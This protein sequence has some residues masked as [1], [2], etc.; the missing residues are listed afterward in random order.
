M[1]GLAYSSDRAFVGTPMDEIL[2]PPLPDDHPLAYAQL[3]PLPAPG[4]WLGAWQTLL[5]G[6][7]ARRLRPLQLDPGIVALAE[8]LRLEDARVGPEAGVLCARAGISAAWRLTYGQV[9]PLSPS[10]PWRRAA[11]LL[12]RYDSWLPP[13][14]HTLWYRSLKR[15]ADHAAFEGRR[16]DTTGLAHGHG[17]RA[18][19]D[20]EPVPVGGALGWGVR[21]LTTAC[22]EGLFVDVERVCLR[23][24]LA[25]SPPPAIALSLGSS[26]DPATDWLRWIMARERARLLW[27]RQYPVHGQ[28]VL[29]AA[30]D[31]DEFV[32]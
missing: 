31:T 30:I 28:L 16:L 13:T 18:W 29:R 8:V 23:P 19:P 6:H 32:P 15:L 3:V 20:D 26:E 14:L 25:A 22:S 21:T 7:T 27:P 9:R 5:G 24:T 12:E 17:A 10:P 4:N 1:L 2:A 11:D